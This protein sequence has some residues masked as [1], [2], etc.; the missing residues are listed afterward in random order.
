MNVIE[1]EN[2]ETK[3]HLR[4]DLLFTV[5][6]EWHYFHWSAEIALFLDFFRNIWYFLPSCRQ[7]RLS[8]ILIDLSANS[9]MAS[10]F[11]K[12]C[13]RLTYINRVYIL[14]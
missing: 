6:L 5:E 13:C 11:V 1:T 3:I 4:N 12:S 7:H 10:Y 8:K 2:Q 9:T 14:K